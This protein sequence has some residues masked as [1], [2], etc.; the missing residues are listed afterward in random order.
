MA[1]VCLVTVG[2]A[3]SGAAHFADEENAMIGSLNRTGI[4]AAVSLA[5]AMLAPAA[6]AQTQPA[7]QQAAPQD[8][9]AASQADTGPAPTDTELKNF[10]GAV[11]DVQNIKDSLQPE[12]ASAKT[13]D[14]R[15][16][17]QQSAEKKMEAVVESHQL[18]PKR[19]VQIANLVQSDSGVRAKVQK[20]MPP[21]PAQQPQQPP[22]S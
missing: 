13:P 8:N 15:T 17:L 2:A 22:A 5:I 6:L 12:L 4:A 19:Y 10:A 9:A 21:Q 14:D 18:S 3:L 20:F 7:P 16:K 1:I 11:V